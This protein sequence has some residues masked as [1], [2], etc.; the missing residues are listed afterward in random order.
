MKIR[1]LPIHNSKSISQ[2]SLPAFSA[3]I[4]IFAC[5][6]VCVCE[7]VWGYFLYFNSKKNLHTLL[8][9][10]CFPVGQA[11]AGAWGQLCNLMVFPSNSTP[12]AA[13][14]PPHSV[15]PAA[16]SPT[17]RLHILYV[18]NPRP[19]VNHRPQTKNNTYYVYNALFIFRLA[20]QQA[21][22][23]SRS[24]WDALE[25]RLALLLRWLCIILTADAVKC[26]QPP[27]I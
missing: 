2:L 23:I 21:Y 8:S 25:C 17:S 10:L 1:I 9:L 22:P 11:M 20:D 26:H 12:S 27:K 5:I 16:T 7:C 6:R 18:T 4:F 14:R 3:S 15:A 24:R 13:A 19:I